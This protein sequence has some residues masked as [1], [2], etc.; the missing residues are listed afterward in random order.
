MTVTKR[1]KY[2][3]PFLL[4]FSFTY[5]SIQ[6]LMG[7]SECCLLTP[8]DNWIPFIPEF[9]WIYHTLIPVILFTTIIL[10]KTRREFFVAYNA[11]VMATIV[12]FLFFIFMPSDYPRYEIETHYPDLSVWLVKLTRLMDKAN[13]TF[14][15]THVTFSCLMFLTASHTKCLEN[16]NSLKLLYFVWAALV[17]ASTL[18]LK[19]HYVLDVASGIV[20]AVACYYLSQRTTNII[21]QNENTRR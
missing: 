12:L 3:V 2:V 16:Y 4:I 21:S 9:I 1:T 15:S 5:S 6:H 8:V 11:C 19:Q 7:H 20:L 14:P 10:V 13:N 18:F 17:F